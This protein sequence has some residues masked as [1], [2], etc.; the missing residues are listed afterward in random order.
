MLGVLDMDGMGELAAGKVPGPHSQVVFA[1]MACRAL[2]R[3]VHKEQVPSTELVVTFMPKLFAV[4]GPLVLHSIVGSIDLDRELAVIEVLEGLQ[5]I[6]GLVELAL[7]D[8]SREHLLTNLTMLNVIFP[9]PQVVGIEVEV[10][11][12]SRQ[13]VRVVDVG[14]TVKPQMWISFCAA[15][16]T[17]C[18][19]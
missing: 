14:D 8:T 11:T 5:R 19:S 9:D 17:S 13:L 2:Q 16:I 15:S 10:L 4:G 6:A 18:P 7:L 1:C 3:R 12:L